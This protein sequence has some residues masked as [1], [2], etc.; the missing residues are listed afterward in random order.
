MQLL[1]ME[2]FWRA[3]EIA[4]PMHQYYTGFDTLTIAQI[5]EVFP[6][7]DVPEGLHFEDVEDFESPHTFTEIN[8]SSGSRKAGTT[9]K[10]RKHSFTPGLVC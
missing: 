6:E 1:T 3:D 10:W 9:A 8:S 5:E 2:A 4:G 7:D